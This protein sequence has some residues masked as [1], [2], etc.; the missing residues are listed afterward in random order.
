MQKLKGVGK[1]IEY[2][3]QALLIGKG[4]KDPRIINTYE[5]NLK[6]IKKSDNKTKKR[7]KKRF[8]L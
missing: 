8:K 5:K 2:Y 4:V 3:E 1:A 7:R 6:K